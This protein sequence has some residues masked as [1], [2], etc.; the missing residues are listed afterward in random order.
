MTTTVDLLARLVEFPTLSA[1][2]NLDL[3]GFVRDYLTQ[4]GF[5]VT[6]IPDRSGTK[7]GLYAQIGPPGAGV[8]V[9]GHTDVVP[10][11][12]QAW[13]RPPFRLTRDGD[14]VYG[15]GT[16]DMKG[17][18]A[19]VLALADRAAPRPLS[20]PLK[21][22]LSYDEEIGCVG[23]RDMLD[24]L[25]ALMGAPRACIVG[26][27][28]QMQ[29]ATGHKG[30]SALGAVCHGQSGHSAAA[31]QFV[32]ALHL[33]TDFVGEL[34]RIQQDLAENGAR[35]PAYAIPYSTVHV[36]RMSG[37]TALNIVPGT[38]TLDF[39]FRHLASDR[40]EDILNRIE[41]AAR[42]A[43]EPYRTGYAEARIEVARHNSYPGL[44]VAEHADIVTYAKGLAQTDAVTRVGF[45]T[46]AGYFDQAGIPTV[47]CG[48]GSMD[49]QGHQPDEFLT[50]DALAGCDR[51]LD[52]LLDDLAA[53]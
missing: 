10:V 21:I 30:K 18:V 3:I 17:F 14:R 51:M 39:E 42:R 32:N 27:P 25:P 8:M 40:A 35:D 50:L 33:A 34:R 15:R 6:L 52:R 11:E 5:A 13:T 7:A 26:E 49:G 41:Q 1:A 16:T 12:G 2:S 23:I 19:S 28:T 31:P 53:D 20:E 24:A 47:V 43:A 38:A 37:G 48:P 46:E 9:S 29:V 36:G 44:D 45:G 4:R 22:V